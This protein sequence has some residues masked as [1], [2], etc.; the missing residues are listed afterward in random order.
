MTAE[1]LLE[2][3]LAGGDI[4]PQNIRAGE[5]AEILE[6]IEDMLASLVEK[7]NAVLTKDDLVIG[8]VNIKEGSVHLQFSSKYPEAVLPAFHE[9]SKSVNDNDFNA[10]PHNAVKSLK[11]F[12]AFIRRKQCNAE[13]IARNGTPKERVLAVLSPDIKITSLE[14]LHGETVIYGKVIRVGGR[15]PKNNGGNTGWFNCLL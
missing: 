9:V 11:N 8:L 10:L 14:P 13:F 15:D 5:M 6:A 12:S 4:A 2:I 7:D 1:S 3:R